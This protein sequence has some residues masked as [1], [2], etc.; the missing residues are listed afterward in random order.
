MSVPPFPPPAGEPLRDVRE[1][2]EGR[3]EGAALWERWGRRAEEVPVQP[4]AQPGVPAG[5]GQSQTQHLREEGL[6]ARNPQGHI[7][8]F[9]S[10]QRERATQ[11]QC[12]NTFHVINLSA[13][14]CNRKSCVNCK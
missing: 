3:G 8:S 2:P 12:V 13:H 1:A 7:G 5:R 4:L 6:Q 9:R 10:A 11:T 14:C